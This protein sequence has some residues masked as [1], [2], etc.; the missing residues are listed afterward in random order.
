MALELLVEAEQPWL[1]PQGMLALSISLVGNRARWGDG[2]WKAG[3][4]GGPCTHR[5]WAAARMPLGSWFA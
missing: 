5:G 2:P 1:P 3:L 4:Q